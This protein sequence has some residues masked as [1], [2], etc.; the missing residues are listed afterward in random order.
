MRLFRS[1]DTSQ[2]DELPGVI[3]T[4]TARDVP[5]NEYGLIY[6]DQPVLYGPGSS[7][8]YTDRIRFIGDQVALIIA[9]SEEI[10]SMGRNLIR[11]DYEDLPVVTDMEQ[12]MK[13]GSTLL[14][15]DRES[16]VFCHYRIRKGDVE[17]HFKPM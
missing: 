10:A 12:A 2:A 4:F 15:P 5:V 17:L 8:P 1:V 16:N 6:N 7:K 13:Q 11:V 14:H 9:E 3:A